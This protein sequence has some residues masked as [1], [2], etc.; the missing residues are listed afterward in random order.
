MQAWLN[1]R[2]LAEGGQDY[3]LFGCGG[4]AQVGKGYFDSESGCG[5]DGAIDNS[6][7]F[8]VGQPVGA[9]GFVIGVE[10]KV[11]GLGN[12]GRFGLRGGGFGAAHDFS[13][14]M[15]C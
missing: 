1:P 13:K 11:N 6:D 9:K 3:L 15:Y 14:V 7:S 8:W 12:N 10:H 2:A 5:G 4:L